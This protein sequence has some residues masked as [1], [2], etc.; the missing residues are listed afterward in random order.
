MY[1][2]SKLEPEVLKFWENNNIYES[3]KKKNSKGKKFYFL[4][5]PPYTSGRLHL[6][7][8]WNNSL[9]DLVM[10]YKRM[11]GFDVWD[12]AGY[13][14]HG[15]PTE[16]K[17]QNLFKLS[18]K[19]D[20]LRFGLD[21]FIKECGKF[22]SDN[23]E[24]I[25]NDLK[26]LGIWMDFEH[27]YKP[28]ENSYISG[29]WMLIKEAYKKNRLYEGYRSLSWCAHHQTA[30]AKHEQEYKEIT[31]DSVFVK[32][33]LKSK[34]DEYLIIWTTTP[35][36]IAFNLAV[37][38]NPEI[39]YIRAKVG[40]ETWI[41]AKDLA[42]S[43]I[44]GVAGKKFTVL[45]EFKGKKLSGLEYI[46]PW[47]DEIQEFKELK[48]NHAKVHTIILS[49]EYVSLSAGSGL[50]HC[51]PGCGPEDYE[52]GHKN[53]L[54]PYNTTSE[55]GIFSGNMGKLS[56]LIAKKDDKKFIESLK[57]S[58]N[59]VAVVKVTHEYPHCERCNNPIIFR[60]TRQW[61]FKV[62]DLKKKMLAANKKISWVPVSGKN[63]FDS[64][65][66]NLRDNSITKQRFWGTPVPIWKCA[67]CKEFTVIGS[68]S[69][70]RKL[71]DKVPDNLHKPWIDEVKI[72]CSCG[73][74]QSRI[75][76][77]LDVW[78]DAGT[79]SWNCLYYPE[80]KD[81]FEKFF[82]ADFILEAREQVRGWFNLLMVASMLAFEKAPFKSVYMHGMLTD[83]S[84]VKMSKSLGNVISPYEIIDK[85]GADTVRYFTFTVA[86]GEDMNF[87]WEEI[88]LRYR[89]LVVFWN[90]HNYLLDLCNTS[91]LKPTKLNH[92][93]IEEK[94][95]IS[96]LNSTIKHVT[97]NLDSY[98]IDKITNQ[99]EDLLLELSRTYI[100]LI[101][102]KATSTNKQKQTVINCVH[103]VLLESIKMLSV[104][105]PFITEGIYQNL[106]KEFNLKE[107]SIH[108]H[109]WPK[110]DSKKIS[111]DLETRFSMAKSTI[112]TILAEREKAKINVRWPLQ[113]AMV[114]LEK[115]EE[116][117]EL[118]SIIQK[119]ANLKELILKKGQFSVE[120]DTKLT[121]ELE[122]EGY[123]RELTRRI[124]SLRK[125]SG[126]TKVDKIN[127]VV[128]SKL[129]L[130][131]WINEL[132]DKVGA[133][134]LITSLPDK[135]YS[136]YSKE[137][138][139]DVTFE[140][141]LDI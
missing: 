30:L 123:T 14:M 49:K 141:Y 21:R 85:Y 11:K 83:V 9:K 71:A 61:F 10:R 4:Q 138:I 67:S 137:V 17:V 80:R 120:L 6:G 65:L 69:E 63:A 124:Q 113:K 81:Y 72:K 133:K 118:V 73:N 16:V 98:N 88:A 91:G 101:R 104:V 103:H 60:T 117:K 5:G 75:P 13:D 55:L 51:A 100:Q 53:N 134:T 42:V 39:D 110:A 35:W 27:A 2:P 107:L 102:D 12:R 52:V 96:K 97:E 43:V 89:N 45:D 26:R 126:L 19:E 86:A 36:T 119:Q 44:T 125:K 50:V 132:K 95:I 48:K 121:P 33:K 77:V 94:Y 130:G 32:F 7:H 41:V 84:G 139:K 108:H 105:C 99:I 115:P 131:K 25:N 3:L 68:E 114:Q 76:D 40:G 106:R 15:L 28:I 58:G 92:L 47:I 18:T 23:A 116:L 24:L 74:M 46:H 56:G 59:I 34:K 128:V 62:E 54:P 112:Q 87:S 64:W 127:I 79:A 31:E 109:K 29:E 37:M 90:I 140:I 38:V 20:I 1:D 93:D 111:K 122:K 82:P 78:I 129:D 136:T 8:A 66:E 57:D 135:K 70:L 22:S